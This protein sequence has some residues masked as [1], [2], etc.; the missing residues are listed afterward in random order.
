MKY[1]I[2]GETVVLQLSAEEINE[3]I[4]SLERTS[5]ESELLGGW[6]QFRKEEFA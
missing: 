6:Y 1:T 5:P 3:V 2:D 4:E